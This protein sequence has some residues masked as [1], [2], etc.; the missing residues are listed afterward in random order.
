MLQLLEISFHHQLAPVLSC[1]SCSLLARAFSRVYLLY[2]LSFLCYEKQAELSPP[3]TNWFSISKSW[4]RMKGAPSVIPGIRNHFMTIICWRSSCQ[5]ISWQVPAPVWF[6][7]PRQSTK[8]A[9]K[10]HTAGIYC[11]CWTIL[12]WTEASSYFLVLA[13]CQRLMSDMK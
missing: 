1:N 8:T 5:Y 11:N 6:Y 2:L 3:L 10:H 9:R 13:G 7:L 12:D 4:K